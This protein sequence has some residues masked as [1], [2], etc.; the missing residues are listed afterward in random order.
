MEC[1]TFGSGSLTFALISNFL[2]NYFPPRHWISWAS[3]LCFCFCCV[4][5]C[6]SIWKKSTIWSQYPSLLDIYLACF[7]INSITVWKFTTI[8]TH[9]F[10]EKGYSYLIW[11]LFFIGGNSL[12]GNEMERTS[13]WNLIRESNK[14]PWRQS[15]ESDTR[16]VPCSG[17]NLSWL[18]NWK[19]R[20]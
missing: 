16:T 15:E 8:Y 9:H 1:L 18:I 12:H 10:T 4:M 14:D 19:D 5:F 6:F 11:F 2:Q 7:Q 3:R 13:F 20:T 17:S